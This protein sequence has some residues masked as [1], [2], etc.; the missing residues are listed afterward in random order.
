VAQPFCRDAGGS[1]SE[2]HDSHAAQYGVT[3]TAARL[4]SELKVIA[5]R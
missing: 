4:R 1:L 2:R 5:K 3:I